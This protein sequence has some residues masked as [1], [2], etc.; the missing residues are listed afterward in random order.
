MANRKLAVYLLVMAG[1]TLLFYMTGLIGQNPNNLDSPNSAF[2]KLLLDPEGLRETSLWTNLLL[3][4]EGFAAVG[5]FIAGILSRD[6]GFGVAGVF[7]LFLINLLWDF[8][9][10]VAVVMSYNPVIALLVFA[11]LMVLYVLTWV[12]FVTQR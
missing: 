4:L 7:A 3:V 9:E 10:V 8:I 12:E 2:L 5:V 6:V 11:P 1:L